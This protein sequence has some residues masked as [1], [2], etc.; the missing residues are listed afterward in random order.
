MKCV[1]DY[2]MRDWLW[3]A[4]LIMK[5]VIDYKNTWLIMKCLI[6]YEMRDWL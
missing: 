3:N 2:E 6:D 5:C 4:S 1:I